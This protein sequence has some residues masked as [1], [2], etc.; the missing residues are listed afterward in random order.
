MDVW[1]CI[2]WISKMLEKLQQLYNSLGS[3]VSQAGPESDL[4][5][6]QCVFEAAAVDFLKNNLPRNTGLHAEG[7]R[8]HNL[9]RAEF[10]VSFD[11]IDGTAGFVRSAMNGHRASMILN[12]SSLPVTSV[13][14]IRPAW[15]PNPSFGWVRYAGILN[16]L[17][18]EMFIAG[19]GIDGALHTVESGNRRRLLATPQYNLHSPNVACEVARRENSFFRYLIPYGL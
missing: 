12:G 13:L 4:G 1:D 5:K 6:R 16:V 7:Y 2:P 3:T 15:R 11:P 14:A 19:D 9:E 17:T 10:I 18:G 8:P